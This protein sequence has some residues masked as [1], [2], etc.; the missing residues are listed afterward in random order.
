[1]AHQKSL[2]V[3]RARHRLRQWL[4]R[5]RRHCGRQSD[6]HPLSWLGLP[7][8]IAALAVK[9]PVAATRPFADGAR[10]V[11]LAAHLIAQPLSLIRPTD[12]PPACRPCRPRAVRGEGRGRVTAR[13]SLGPL[14]QGPAPQNSKQSLP[15]GPVGWWHSLRRPAP[16]QPGGSDGYLV[17][18]AAKAGMGADRIAVRRRIVRAYSPANCSS[19]ILA[20]A[21]CI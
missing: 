13:R 18:A 7:G 16:P 19:A 3:F 17:L 20:G 11:P 1:M 4:Q 12:R 9:L 15:S 10:R 14:G 5:W 6:D 21:R 2:L 8:Q